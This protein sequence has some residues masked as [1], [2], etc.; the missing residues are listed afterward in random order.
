MADEDINEP[1][2]LT[3]KGY[4]K[5]FQERDRRARAAESDRDEWKAQAEAAETERARDGLELRILRTRC[6]GL[7]KEV[8]DLGSRLAAATECLR[9]TRGH[10]DQDRRPGSL[11]RRSG[12]LL[13]NQSAAPG[14]L[15]EAMDRDEN[16]RN[17][18]SHSSCAITVDIIDIQAQEIIR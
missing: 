1:L 9:E 3:V 14:T 15:G 5:A 18:Q 4:R 13:A 7:E 2:D 17:Y 6:D 12:A 8:A 16:R 10:I 11:F